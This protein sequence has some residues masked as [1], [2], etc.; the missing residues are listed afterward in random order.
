MEVEYVSKL[1]DHLKIKGILFEKGLSDV[2]IERVERQ[3]KF[4]FPLDLRQLLQYALPISKSFPDW[5]NADEYT[6]AKQIRWAAD[7]I[8]FDI[9]HNSFWLDDWGAR[10]D[11]LDMACRIARHELE[12]VPALVPISSHRFIPSEPELEGNP[13]FSVYQTDIIYYGADLATYFA[14]EFEMPLPI[15]AATK[16]RHIRFWEDLVS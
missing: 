6:L 12:K 15:W 16:P 1:V 4:K 2:E 8:C 13:V 10:P 11:N 9:I 14:A 3:F 5:R 7:G